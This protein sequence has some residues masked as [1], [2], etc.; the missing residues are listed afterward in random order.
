MSDT[1]RSFDVDEVATGLSV[2]RSLR[3]SWVITDP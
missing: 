1:P 2:N 3:I